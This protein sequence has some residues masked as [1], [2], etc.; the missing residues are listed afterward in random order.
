MSSTDF[1][2]TSPLLSG[3]EATFE[4]SPSLFENFH[5]E[6]ME[7]LSLDATPPTATTASAGGGGGGGAGAE[8]GSGMGGMAIMMGVGMLAQAGGM[9]AQGYYGYQSDL[10]WAEATKSIAATRADVT[11]EVARTNASTTI[12]VAGMQAMAMIQ[13]ANLQYKQ[14]MAQLYFANLADKRQHSLWKDQLAG[15]IK[16]MT[17]NYN[18]QIHADNLNYDRI[19]TEARY[20][21]IEKR[22]EQRLAVPRDEQ[23]VD[24][25]SLFEFA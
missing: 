17:L 22:A 6:G 10:R 3:P 23:D 5:L 19:M 1:T 24:E 14:Q 8:S 7:S 21:A 2:L 20:A 15:D 9:I 13:Q 11:K 4:P 25:A 12:K 16:T 18:A